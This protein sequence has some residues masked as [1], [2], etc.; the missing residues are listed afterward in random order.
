MHF[1]Y[2]LSLDM[3]RR[4]EKHFG[5]AVFKPIFS[6]SNDKYFKFIHK[7]INHKH[8]QYKYTNTFSSLKTI[9]T[10][11]KMGNDHETLCL[12]CHFSEHTHIH[13]HMHTLPGRIDC[14]II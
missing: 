3:V 10:E 7:F 12:R 6:S 5:L 14:N 2:C 13:T 11:T 1:L 9:K 4:V 8:Y